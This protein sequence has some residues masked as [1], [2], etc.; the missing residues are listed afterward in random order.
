MLIWADGGSMTVHTRH[1]K[2]KT[3]WVFYSIYVEEF[4]A[5]TF[6]QRDHL[7]IQTVQKHKKICYT[8]TVKNELI[9]RKITVK[10]KWMYVAYTV[11]MIPALPII[12]STT[13]RLRFLFWF[14]LVSF[15][16]SL[17]R[18]SS[19]VEWTTVPS[20]CV[21]QALLHQVQS[22]RDHRKQEQ[23][24]NHSRSNDGSQRCCKRNSQLYE[25]TDK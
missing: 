13:E 4:L 25:Q 14:K 5:D 3:F 6:L 19:G 2:H 22:G 9:W 16:Q 17:T 23:P 12:E 24:W 20:V 1:L 18:W 7:K 21:T 8:C 11:K 15:L 10:T